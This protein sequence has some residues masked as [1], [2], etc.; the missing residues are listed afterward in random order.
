MKYLL[1]YFCPFDPLQPSQLHIQYTVQMAEGFR[2]NAP[3]TKLEDIQH[4]IK[5]TTIPNTIK[6]HFKIQR[7]QHCKML[8]KTLQNTQKT[9]LQ[10]AKKT[11]T[12]N[13]R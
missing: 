10:N 11:K 6:Y 7:K 2:H 4:Q 9:T 1:P 3:Q 8:A 13:T 12:Q 5:Q